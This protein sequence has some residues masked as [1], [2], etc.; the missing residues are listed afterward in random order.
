MKYAILII[1]SA[2]GGFVAAWLSFKAVMS[3]DPTFAA[4]PL[5]TMARPLIDTVRPSSPAPARRLDFADVENAGNVFNQLH[6][7]WQLAAQS[8]IP[9]I[10][11][12]VRKCLG[13]TDPLYTDTISAI[14][15]ERYTELNPAGAMD[16][17]THEPRLNQAALQAE[18]LTSW[19]S[20][21]PRAAVDYFKTITD[22]QIKMKVGARLLADPALARAGL[23]DQVKRALGPMSNVILHRLELRNTNPRDL[24]NSAL[25]LNGTKRMTEMASAVSRWAA[26]DPKAALA[27]IMHLEDPNERNGML[28]IAIGSYSAQDPKG[29]L[30]WLQSN[31]PGNSQLQLQVLD[32]MAR[33]NVGQALPLVEDFVRRTGQTRA[34]SG[35]IG[36]WAR[37]DP[38][39]AIDYVQSLGSEDKRPLY[40]SLAFSYMQSDPVGALNWILSLGPRYEAIKTGLQGQIN[41]ENVSAAEQAL[42][43]VTDPDTRDALIKGIANYKAGNDP[44]AAL[45]WLDENADGK[46]YLDAYRNVLATYSASHPSQAADLLD[47]SRSGPQIYAAAE[48][49]AHNW[50]RR[51]PQAAA[52]WAESLPDS[53]AKTG[54]M[55]MLVMDTAV[56]HP[57]KAFAMSQ[58]LPQKERRKLASSIGFS[59]V[60]RDPGDVEAIIARLKPSPEVAAQLRRLASTRQ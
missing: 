34:L 44:L 50:F 59:W 33:L 2:F 47:S 56:H 28:R 26:Q 41:V 42:Q 12:L 48:S 52:N 10:K 37:R 31:L 14:F 8:N 38:Q 58:S 5:V 55:N 9:A 11:S 57:R 40:E 60:S 24:F 23:L 3:S 7:A 18:V 15:I 45:Q 29:A 6:T 1:V 49:I 46:A 51:D 16:F 21:N 30:D 36:I 19:L 25:Q 17:V 13:K 27:R 22:M 43:D 32:A 20:Y 54:A 35:I 4:K 53:D 39:Q